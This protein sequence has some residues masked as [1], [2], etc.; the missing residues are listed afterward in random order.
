M[1]TDN[2]VVL[3]IQ[4]RLSISRKKDVFLILMGFRPERKTR[5]I[6]D[7]RSNSEIDALLFT[8]TSSLRRSRK[9]EKRSF[10]LL[11]RVMD[12]GVF[13]ATNDLPKF[14]LI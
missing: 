7:F 12:R 5:T 8:M 10:R 4:Y 9:S 14:F 2:N 3:T 1:K 13:V 6:V 11:S